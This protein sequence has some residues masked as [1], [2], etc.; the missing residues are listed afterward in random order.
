MMK[1]T[2]WYTEMYT[3]GQIPMEAQQ[4]QTITGGQMLNSADHSSPT[5][6]IFLH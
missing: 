1:S 3:M 6:V 4:L 5:K 2:F